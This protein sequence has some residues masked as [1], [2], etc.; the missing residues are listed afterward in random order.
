MAMVL[1]LA[2]CATAT[3]DPLPSDRVPPA[4][5][6]RQADA[7]DSAVVVSPQG[8]WWKTFEDPQLDALI[9]LAMRDSPGIRSAAARLAKA[10][11]VLGVADASRQPQLGVSGGLNQQGGPLVNAAGGSG[12]LWTLGATASYEVDLFGRIAK[13]LDATRFDVAS[14]EALLQSAGLLLQAELAQ[15]YFSLR[16][17]DAERSVLD[18]TIKAHLETLRVAERRLAMGSVAELEVARLRGEVAAAQSESFVLE[19]R[20]AELE[21][22]IAALAGQA[23]STYSVPEGEW[24]A[25]LPFIPAGIP[26]TVL[27]RRADVAAARHTLQASQARLGLAKSA[28]FPNLSLTASQGFASTGW[29]DLI[30]ASAHAWSVGAFLSLPLLDGGQR[31]AQTRGAD[32]DLDAAAASYREQGLLAFR[33]VEDQL[34]S[35]RTLAG[36]ERALESALQAAQRANIL[37]TSRYNRGLSSQLD[38]LDAQRA[39]LHNQRQLILVRQ[40]RFGSTVGLIRA[41]GGG[42]E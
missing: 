36:Q 27:T 4:F 21:H 1:A 38:L 2:A 5:R 13:D 15:N 12:T 7:P 8:G 25:V 24:R 40:L 6:E 33:E 35:L 42:W 3:P 17:L 39:E 10:R 19:R 11:S 14:R 31:E 32:A 30:A 34:S 29:R 28:W 22:A 37:V 20:R 23:V 18:R 9:A 26:S 41:L 16:W